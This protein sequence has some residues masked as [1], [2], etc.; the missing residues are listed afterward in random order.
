MSIKTTIH[1]LKKTI[2]LSPAT[3]AQAKERRLELT[4]FATASEALTALLPDSSL[5]AD[6]RDALALA[7][8]AEQ[9]REH[10]PLWQAMLIVAYEPMLAKF[11]SKRTRDADERESDVL[12]AFLEALLR[13]NCAAPP[14][15]LPLHL[16]G[17]TSTLLRR[18]MA[19]EL[20]DDAIGDDDDDIDAAAASAPLEEVEVSELIGQLLAKGATEVLGA[21]VAVHVEH[22][23]LRAHVESTY[24]P[25]SAREQERLYHRL[26]RET[27]T[28]VARIRR[29]ERRASVPTAA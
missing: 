8:I 17:M 10:R 9:Q 12:H 25:C 24:A 16:K 7:I 6:E 27:R 3:F 26:R 29:R 5:S 28:V 13:V 2:H 19:D 4:P 18:S 22:Q 21:V 1:E 23:S 20:L 14:R 11:C 15:F